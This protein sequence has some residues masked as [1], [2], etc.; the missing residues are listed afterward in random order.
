[1]DSELLAA[2]EVM[3]GNDVIDVEAPR[4]ALVATLSIATISVWAFVGLSCVQALA[5]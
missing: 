4:H 2:I 1:M 3:N 5:I